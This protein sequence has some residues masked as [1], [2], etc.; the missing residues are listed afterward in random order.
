MTTTP[1]SKV[2]KNTSQNHQQASLVSLNSVRARSKKKNP[3]DLLNE[4]LKTDQT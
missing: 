3:H 4:K 2:Q 1:K